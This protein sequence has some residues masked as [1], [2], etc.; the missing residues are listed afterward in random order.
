LH[1]ATVW[2]RDALYVQP[3][4]SAEESEVERAVTTPAV[5]DSTAR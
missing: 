2:L 3:T 4:D 1:G 5:A